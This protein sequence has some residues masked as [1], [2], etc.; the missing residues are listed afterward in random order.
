MTKLDYIFFTL[1]Y[2][3]IFMIIL[4]NIIHSSYGDLFY[5]KEIVKST[6]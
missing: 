2:T 3:F 6:I 5:M 1:I 4:S